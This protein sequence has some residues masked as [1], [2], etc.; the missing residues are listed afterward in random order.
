MLLCLHEELA[1][2]AQAETLKFR[3]LV[4]ALLVYNP[5]SSRETPKMF[6]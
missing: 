6:P 5:P 2:V 4:R 3:A 1:T